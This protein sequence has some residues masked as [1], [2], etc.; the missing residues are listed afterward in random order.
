MTDRPLLYILNEAGE[1]EPIDD[2]LAWGRWMETANRRVAIDRDE[3][4]HKQQIV[5]STVFLGCDHGHGDGPPVLYETMAFD[6]GNEI[7]C[8]RYCTRDDALRGH[9]ELCQAMN[10]A[11]RKAGA[12]QPHG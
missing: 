2:T 12:Q 7:D 11:M 5:I 9:Q 8:R 10:L 1:P 6:N 3:G 4:D